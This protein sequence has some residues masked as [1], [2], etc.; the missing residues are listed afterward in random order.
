[1]AT[2]HTT[3]DKFQHC[4]ALREPH[5]NTVAM[6]CPHTG[7]GVEFSPGNLVEAALGGCVLISMGTYALRHSLDLSGARVDVKIESTDT[8]RMRFKSI[9]VAVTM[10]PGLEKKNRVALERAADS[11]PIKHSFAIDIPVEVQFRWREQ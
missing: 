5:G 3:Y 6:D 7:K 10:P 1:M 11:C 2:V 9:G 4:V 8:P